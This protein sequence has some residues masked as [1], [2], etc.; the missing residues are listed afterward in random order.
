MYKKPT[1]AY[2]DT[3]ATSS[4]HGASP[5]KLITL[6]LDACQE[7]LAIAKG[8]IERNDTQR[9]AE[10]IKKAVDVVTQLQGSLDM[11]KGGLIARNLDDL[12]TFCISHLA[13]AN[14][15]N[16]SSKLDEVYKVISEIKAGWVA[17]DPAQEGTS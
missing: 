14:V 16:D 10:A 7:N 1:S 6:L 13:L 17:I 8:G 15:L 11:E 9:K 5:H 3:R 4:V 2:L 12:Y